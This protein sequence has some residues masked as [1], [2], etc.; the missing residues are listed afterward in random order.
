[1]TRRLLVTGADGF[2]GRY[3]TEAMASRGWA[4]H[5]L[6]H[7]TPD[8]PVAGLTQACVADLTDAQAVA[9]VV[10]Q[11]QP[12]HVAHLAAIAFVAHGD[13]EA[14][15]RTNLVGTRHLM[16]A[17]TTLTER[18]QSVL[19]AS[20]A[21]VYGN[22]TAGT[23]DEK[24]APAPANDYAV[25]KLAMEHVAHLYADR[26]P[27][28]VA[29]PFNYTGVGQGLAFLLPK[30]VD[31]V[32][33]RAEVIELGNI[34]VA[35]DFS[36]VRMVVDAYSRLLETPAAVGGTF[37]VCSGKAYTLQEVLDLACDVAGHHMTV[38]VNPAFVRANEV[39]VLLGSRQKLE[40]CIGPLQPYALRDT[41]AWMLAGQGGA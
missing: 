35:R 1:M 6:V 2:T 24:V 34:D 20:S 11:V 15:Y 16:Q 13:A 39:K 40:A 17:L 38:R 30:I 5:G 10:E 19:L 27:S 29:R 37:N 32:R 36:D 14:M 31:H 21:N 25:S 33:R 41:L 18:P 7:R 8:T 23:I 22:S 9:R 28:V 12:T 26:L 3:L 4:V